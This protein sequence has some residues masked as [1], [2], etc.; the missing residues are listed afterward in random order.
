MFLFFFKLL[1]N[2]L[3]NC[4]GNLFFFSFT[5]LSLLV[6]VASYA[7]FKESEYNY[8]KVAD[9]VPGSGTAQGNHAAAG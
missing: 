5:E 7:Y 6:I 4:T 1:S 3:L 2:I 8:F 9:M